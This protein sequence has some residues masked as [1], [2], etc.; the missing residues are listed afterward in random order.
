MIRKIRDRLFVG[1]ESACQAGTEEQAV[2]H[3]CKSPCYKDAI[4]GAGTLPHDHPDRHAVEENFDQYLHLVDRP[5]PRFHLD[6]FEAFFAFATAHWQAGRDLRIHC[7]AGRSRSP[8]LAL[9][10]LAGVTGDI[11]RASFQQAGRAYADADPKARPGRGL[12][13]FLHDRWEDL[14]EA[15]D[16]RA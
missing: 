3:A 14:M 10:F 11:P 16:G 1:D 4:G 15:A 12:R 5:Q 2:V 13:R 7:H 6:V 8:T 9:L